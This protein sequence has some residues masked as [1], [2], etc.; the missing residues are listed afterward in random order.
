MQSLF[1]SSTWNPSEQQIEGESAECPCRIE[2]CL[3]ER[4]MFV[5][6]DWHLGVCIWSTEF[7][8]GAP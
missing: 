4:E 3:S 2:G 8:L 6:S 1:V 5:P 7:I